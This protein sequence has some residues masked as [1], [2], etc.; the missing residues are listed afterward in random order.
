MILAAPGGAVCVAAEQVDEPEWTCNGTRPTGV[1]C[2][3]QPGPSPL[4]VALNAICGTPAPDSPE[5]RAFVGEAVEKMEARR[6]R[7]S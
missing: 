1:P 6:S 3:F 7:R 5:F 4:V 2:L